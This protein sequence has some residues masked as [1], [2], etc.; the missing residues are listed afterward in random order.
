MEAR[1]RGIFLPEAGLEPFGQLQV[2]HPQPS[3]GQCSSRSGLT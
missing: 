2:H 1:S 3:T